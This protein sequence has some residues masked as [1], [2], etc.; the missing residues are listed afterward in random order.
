[1][2]IIHASGHSPVIVAV[3]GA[4]KF[5]RYHSSGGTH[6]KVCATE[7]FMPLLRNFFGAAHDKYQRLYD[8]R[9]D[10]VRLAG[11][12]SDE[13]Q[14]AT[15][16]ADDAVAACGANLRYARERGSNRGNALIDDKCIAGMVCKHVV[17]VQG[18]FI[19]SALHENYKMMDEIL[20]NY[21]AM[22]G[23]DID[24]FCFDVACR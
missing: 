3:D 2:V 4:M 12:A 20:S 6:T 1:L 9:K 19:S 7:G 21:F 23:K 13:M 24:V 8:I 18:S 14:A 15:E 16:A 11:G 10:S 5:S 22:G 17:P